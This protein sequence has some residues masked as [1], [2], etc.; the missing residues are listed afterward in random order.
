VI[1]HGVVRVVDWLKPDERR[2]F[3]LLQDAKPHPVELDGGPTD[4]EVA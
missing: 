2:R 4:A 3:R 1:S